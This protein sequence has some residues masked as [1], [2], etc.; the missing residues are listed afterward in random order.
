MH[1]YPPSVRGERREGMLI[2]RHG[3]TKG[4]LTRS[5]PSTGKGKR[6]KK[7]SPLNTYRNT[8]FL[9]YAA[10]SCKVDFLQEMMLVLY[11]GREFRSGKL[12]EK[13]AVRSG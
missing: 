10:V 5:R 2:A 6:W 13:M 11:S 12:I 3:K 7:S 1:A 9:R 8:Q 4:K